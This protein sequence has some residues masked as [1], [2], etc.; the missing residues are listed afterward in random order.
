MYSCLLKVII[1]RKLEE[2]KNRYNALKEMPIFQKY[3]RRGQ[4][5]QNPFCRLL[6]K[7]LFVY[8]RNKSLVEMP[9]DINIG[10]GLYLGHPYCITIN[11]KAII[12]KNCNEIMKISYG[13]I[14][15][16]E[17]FF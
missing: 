6:Y 12:G 13:I 17:I 2:D 9:L 3:M 5:A 8:Y 11:P 16:L 10:G 7:I 15:P 4:E 1:M 14:M